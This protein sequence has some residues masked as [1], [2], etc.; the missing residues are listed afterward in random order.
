MSAR[1]VLGELGSTLRLRLSTPLAP[2]VGT[3]RCMSRI[4]S[5]ERGSICRSSGL[6]TSTARQRARL[7]ATL[8]GLMERA[9]QARLKRGD[10]H[11]ALELAGRAIAVDSSMRPGQR[12]GPSPHT[13]AY[14]RRTT[15]PSVRC[16]QPSSTASCASEPTPSTEHRVARLLSAHTTCRLQERSQPRYSA[17]PATN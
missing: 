9:G 8:I 16:A 11:G 3:A 14:S 12:Y 1:E 4:R 6:P 7:D 10:T 13:T 17:D 2:Q 5:M 15:T